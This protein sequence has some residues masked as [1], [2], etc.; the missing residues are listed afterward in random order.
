[1]NELKN[2][3]R[4]LDYTKLTLKS[5]EQERIKAAVVEAKNPKRTLKVS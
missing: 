5:E 4:D 3:H 1:M 2:N